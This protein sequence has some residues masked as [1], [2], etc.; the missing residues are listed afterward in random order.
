MELGDLG[1]AFTQ[2]D[3]L[4]HASEQLSKSSP[5]MQWSVP[6]A[7]PI[8]EHLTEYLPCSPFGHLGMTLVKPLRSL[9]YQG[10]ARAKNLARFKEELETWTSNTIIQSYYS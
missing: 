6:H 1:T 8:S 7:H 5:W 2:Q 3:T 10:A 4:V 9:L